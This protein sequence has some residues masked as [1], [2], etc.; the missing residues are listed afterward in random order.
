MVEEEQLAWWT[1]AMLDRFPAEELVRYRPQVS[2][3]DNAVSSRV[4]ARALV[5][6]YGG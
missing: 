4:Y 1:T 6:S 3:P 2:Q 5:E